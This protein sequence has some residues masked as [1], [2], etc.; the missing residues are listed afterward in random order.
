LRANEFDVLIHQLE[1]LMFFR[2]KSDS[3]WSP[4]TLSRTRQQQR[5]PLVAFLPYSVFKEPPFTEGA[6]RLPNPLGDVKRNLSSRRLK[7]P[8]GARTDFVWPRRTNLVR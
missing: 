3:F 4:D 6:D 2:N 5:N 8:R 7:L 1:R